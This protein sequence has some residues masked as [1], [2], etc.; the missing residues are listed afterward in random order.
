[1]GREEREKQR[2]KDEIERLNRLVPGGGSVSNPVPSSSSP[3]MPHAKPTITKA[4]AAVATQA[5]RKRQLAQL[6]AL[7]V[8]V[9]EEFRK[10]NA[11]IGTWETVSINPVYDESEGSRANPDARSIGVTRE[12]K[13][14]LDEDDDEA[15]SSQN[16]AKRAWAPRFKNYEYKKDEDEEDIEALLGGVKS[17]V[18]AVKQEEE[19]SVKKE[20]PNTEGITDIKQEVP[21]QNHIADPQGPAKTPEA[22]SKEEPAIKAKEPLPGAGIVFKK[23]KPK[24]K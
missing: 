16:P 1:M 23:R 2:T 6:A 18:P 3:S 4:P 15:E 11:M 21:G 9:P 19:E 17:S 8:E 24:P 22:E 20:D 5:D 7:G 14:N 13:R 10:E 12:R